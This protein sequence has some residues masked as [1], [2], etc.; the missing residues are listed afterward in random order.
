MRGLQTVDTSAGKIN[1]V[2]ASVKHF[3]ADGATLYGAN[4]GDAR[5]YNFKTFMNHNIQGYKGAIESEVG[6]VMA[7]YSAINDI[8][9]SLNNYYL[10]NL[11]RTDLGFGG[12]VISD[13]NQANVIETIQLPTSSVNMTE[14]I[15]SATMYYAGVDMFMMPTSKAVTE[16]HIKSV[17]KAL[18]RNELFNDRLVDAAAKIIAVKMAMGLV[19]TVKSPVEEGQEPIDNHHATK[20]IEQVHGSN[21]YIDSLQAVHESLVL[22]KNDNNVLPV[23]ALTSTIQYVVLVGEK[24]ININRLTKLELFRNY[25]NI[26][27]QAGGWSV[28]WQGFMGNDFWTGANKQQSNASSI[29]DALTLLKKRG[30]FNLVYP[31]YTS[32][33][34]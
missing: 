20:T 24:I 30:N 1:G 10:Q 22:L 18:E 31:N 4:Q 29:L 7:S 16:K 33:T 6:T 34:D 11:L 23:R 28:R 27:M 32:Y 25:D 13:Y 21:E 12:F 17:K 9:M 2:V 5:V 19:E 8:P 26:G 3:M 14:E 15:A